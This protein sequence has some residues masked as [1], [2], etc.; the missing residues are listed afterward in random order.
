MTSMR[1]MLALV[2]LLAMFQVNPVAVKAQTITTTI[3]LRNAVTDISGDGYSWNAAD[4]VLTLD[5]L[6]LNVSSDSNPALQLP[7]DEVTIVVHDRNQVVSA[8]SA[9]I[10]SSNLI[11]IK[12][13]GILAV[14]GK[15]AGIIAGSLTLD[16][17]P[18]GG[19]LAIGDQEGSNGENYGIDV[20]P[21]SLIPVTLN[22]FGGTLT[23]QGGSGSNGS[24]GIRTSGTAGSIR[25]DAGTVS[26]TGG[27][28]TSGASY[29]VRANNAIVLNMRGGSLACSGGTSALYVESNSIT[30]P[31]G[32]A[33]FGKSG[34]AYTVETALNNTYHRLSVKNSPY[35]WVL[36][37]K[38]AAVAQGNTVTLTVNKNAAAYTSHGKTF[39]LKKT[40]Q[41]DITGSGTDGTVTFSNVPDGTYDLYDGASDTGVNVV[42]GLGANAAT[43]HYFTVQF[44]VTDAGDATDSTISAMYNGAQIQSG[45]EVIGGSVL[46]I[47]AVGAGASSYTYAWTGTGTSGQTTAALSNVY[48][49]TAINATCTV[50]GSN[51]PEIAVSTTGL[52]NLRVGQAASGAS[53]VYTLSG[54]SYAANITPENFTVADLPAWLSAGTAV[55]TSDTVVTIPLTGTP[56]TAKTSIVVLGYAYTIPAANITGATS[57]VMPTGMISVGAVGKGDGAAVNGAPTVSGT[58]TTSSITVKAATNAGTTGQTVEYAISTSSTPTPATG[59]RS[60]TTFTGLTASTAYYV[61]ARTAEN[62]N[63]DAGTAQVSAAITTA[64]SGGNPDPGPISPAITTQPAAST[65]VAQGGTATLTVAASWPSG[66][67]SYQ[68]YRSVSA[69]NVGGT[70]IN[71]ATSASY[72]TPGDLPAGTYYFYCVI[73]ATGATPAS[74]SVAAVIVNSPPASVSGNNQLSALPGSTFPLAFAVDVRDNESRTLAISLTVGDNTAS[75]THTGNGTAVIPCPASFSA[76]GAYPVTASILGGAPVI[77]GTVNVVDVSQYLKGDLASR[78]NASYVYG[79]A[80]AGVPVAFRSASA[81]LDGATGMLSVQNKDELTVGIYYTG[82]GRLEAR[83]VKMQRNPFAPSGKALEPVPDQTALKVTGKR[84]TA[85][86]YATFAFSARL[87]YRLEPGYYQFE[88]YSAKSGKYAGFAHTTLATIHVIEG[89]GETADWTMPTSLRASLGQQYQL[90]VPTVSGA[91]LPVLSVSSSNKKIATIDSAGILTAKRS[92]KATIKVLTASGSVLKCAVTVASNSFGRTRPLMVKSQAGLYASTRRLYY[93]SGALNTEVFLYNRTGAAIK[94]LENVTFELYDGQTLIH[95]K[96]MQPVLF[97]TVLKNKG[98]KVLKYSIA[99]TAEDLDLGIGRYT[100]VIRGIDSNGKQ[101]IILN[102]GAIDTATAKPSEAKS[103]GS[104]LLK[105]Q[106]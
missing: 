105:A 83:L 71:G 64:S 32:V 22:V 31:S 85:K 82:K 74:S 53:V 101:A 55:R 103:A 102:S 26:A 93:K 43:I 77:V 45:A 70:A 97:K 21:A 4:K 94:G 72:T 18:T 12:G 75:A 69:T 39:K 92:G 88:V 100:A 17:E 65:N 86:Q 24:A 95:S 80:A 28:S 42:A 99:D 33:L 49:D 2:L 87:M 36:D 59:W 30:L 37:A 6:D 15:G 62:T 35:N 76:P 66:S 7:N 5:R 1:W 41:S 19:L 96:A 8:Q 81:E 57:A 14:Q 40:G 58:P 11:N 84:N 20:K 91:V 3:D 13:D 46:S 63:Y 10:L 48:L 16:M 23:A 106:G 34:D 27:L 38:T 90:I 9:G 29:G 98:Y 61:Y 67:I 89:Q 50:T 56:T 73:S 44:A 25:I 104:E 54:A 68:W 79:Q 78:L 51:A 60:G 52:I 47:T